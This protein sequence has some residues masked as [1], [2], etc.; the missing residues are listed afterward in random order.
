MGNSHNFGYISKYNGS[1]CKTFQYV[2]YNY[3]S[4]EFTPKSM[5]LW[6]V[7]HDEGTQYSC[8]NHLPISSGYEELPLKT[9]C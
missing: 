1:E 2:I 5:K 8:K 7:D 9:K 6:C 3:I 4:S